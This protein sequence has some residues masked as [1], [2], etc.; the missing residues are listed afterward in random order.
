M[1]T[2]IAI[3]LATTLVSSSVLAADVGPLAPGKPA[4]VKQ[5]QGEVS[6][7][8]AIWVGAVVVGG[9]LI[10]TSVGQ[11]GA[12]APSGSSAQGATTT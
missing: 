10:G 6:W 9:I 12:V 3:A 11:K 1:R 5:A 4:G 7:N 2:L 8:T